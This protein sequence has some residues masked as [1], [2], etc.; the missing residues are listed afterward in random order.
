MVDIP[1]IIIIILKLEFSFLCI[2]ARS[3]GCLSKWWAE[4]DPS[5]AEVGRSENRNPALAKRKGGDQ[6]RHL[7]L[8]NLREREGQFRMFCVDI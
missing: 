3:S 4:N 6:E 1:S 7:N 8:V 5:D 2:E